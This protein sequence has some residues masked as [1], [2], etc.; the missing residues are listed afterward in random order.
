LA[1]AEG[2]FEWWFVQG[3]SVFHGHSGEER[4]TRFQS[5]T[6]G[7]TFAA[8]E[9]LLPSR[10]ALP[11]PGIV[12]DLRGAGVLP[13]S[14]TSLLLDWRPEGRAAVF[15]WLY[16]LERLDP[17]RI[18][19]RAGELEAR[20]RGWRIDRASGLPKSIELL[21]HA[22]P[23]RLDLASVELDVPLA[24]A[25]FQWPPEGDAAVPDEDES[26]RV[27]Q[28]RYGPL[29]VRRGAYARLEEA[30]RLRRLAW[31][32]RSRAAWKELM[33]KLH[34]EEL[35]AYR[36]GWEADLLAY[37]EELMK[38]LRRFPLARRAEAAEQ[39]REKL[40]E[41]ALSYLD[42]YLEQWPE[43]DGAPSPQRDELLALERAAVSALVAER[44]KEPALAE[45]EERLDA[46]QDH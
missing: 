42:P 8:L 36:A 11:G 22:P 19:R 35:E 30:L 18:E 26:A 43:P 15:A 1:T 13:P 29:P 28:E 34:G 2:G 16:A 32:A 44:A 14:G 4:W 31:D 33:T 39:A 12:L 23:F 41:A 21:G 6:P 10:P 9:A 45:F 17:A 27:Y 5:P 40:V 46:L 24:A 38:W 3:R 20:E 25:L 7:P 37:V